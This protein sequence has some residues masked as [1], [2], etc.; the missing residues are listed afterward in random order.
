MRN[1]ITFILLLL[2]ISLSAPMER[3]VEAPI[4]TIYNPPVTFTAMPKT[5][6]ISGIEVTGA[7]NYDDN[8]IIGFSGLKIG[9]KVDVPGQDLFNASH[10]LIR[11]GL[12]AQAQ[13]KVA[14]IYDDEVWL[15]IALRTHPRISEINYLGMKIKAC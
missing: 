11:Q 10:R 13:I 5:Y 3:A 1:K 8:T 2:S 15:T 12:F 14:K 6:T 7:Q 4:D 9:Q